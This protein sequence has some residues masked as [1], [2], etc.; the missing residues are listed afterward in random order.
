MPTSPPLTSGVDHE[1]LQISVCP[2]GM[3]I[4]GEKSPVEGRPRAT[5]AVMGTPVGR[6][7][8]KVFSSQSQFWGEGFLLLS[9]RVRL[10]P[11]GSRWPHCPSLSTSPRFRSLMSRNTGPFSKGIIPDGGG[12]EVTL[13]WDSG[14]Y[15]VPGKPFQ[16][17]LRWSLDPWECS[18]TPAAC[19]AM[20]THSSFP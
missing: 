5:G 10:A 4:P 3:T 7:L 11:H 6:T 9:L 20:R 1:G 15:L 2:G 19:C 13:Q 17:G 18:G 16:V 8:N 12:P 14:P